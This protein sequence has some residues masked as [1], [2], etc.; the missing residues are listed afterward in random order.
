MF[1]A[2]KAD[3][4]FAEDSTSYD[5]T[6]SATYDPST[7]SVAPGTVTNHGMF[8][9]GLSLDFQGRPVVTGGATDNKVSIFDEES[10][11][12][13]SGQNMTIGRGYHAQITL[14]DGHIFTIGRFLERRSRG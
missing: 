10:D 9:P 4:M 14:S 11:S 13:V 2:D 5:V 12:W 1:A 3:L 6:A 8:C 7:G